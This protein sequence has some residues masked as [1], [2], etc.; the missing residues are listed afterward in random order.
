MFKLELFNMREYQKAQLALV[1]VSFHSY[2]HEWPG[3]P[4]PI[5]T[6]VYL[7]LVGYKDAKINTQHIDFF[8]KN[9][10]DGDTLDENGHDF[11]FKPDDS[12]GTCSVYEL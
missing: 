4:G 12:I 3:P 10:C 6:N 11:L 2:Y 8:E 7:E 5:D 1:I 9:N